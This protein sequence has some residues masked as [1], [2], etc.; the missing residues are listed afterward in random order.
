[1]LHAR[2]RAAA[3]SATLANKA[4]AVGHLG[5][6]SRPRA[7][8]RLKGPNRGGLAGCPWRGWPSS[9]RRRGAV[10]HLRDVRRSRLPAT[11]AEPAAEG[12][13]DW[14]RSA[15]AVGHLR[16]R[17]DRLCVPR[18]GTSALRAVRFGKSRF[19]IGHLRSLSC[20][21]RPVGQPRA[22]AWT[23]PPS[24]LG[25]IDVTGQSFKACRAFSVRT[26]S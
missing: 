20:F 18:R 24:W 22:T 13:Q 12:G 7:A 14:P 19:M 8:V 25:R 5:V 15:G 3:N 23:L 6:S 9:P 16:R 10:G 4:R 2:P 21:R 1:M 17:C 11:R 26:R